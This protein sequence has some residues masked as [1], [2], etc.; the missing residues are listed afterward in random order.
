VIAPARAPA[1]PSDL[2]ILAFLVTLVVMGRT[3]SEHVA[4]ADAKGRL[5]EVV[6][7][8][9]AEHRR[10]VITRHGK[11]AAVLIAV[12]DLESLEDTLDLLSDSDAMASLRRAGEDVSEGRVAYLDKEQAQSRWPRG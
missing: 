12:D 7:G 11:P 8:V 5:S 10:V 2:T 6:D 9:E 4:L 1:A 3:S